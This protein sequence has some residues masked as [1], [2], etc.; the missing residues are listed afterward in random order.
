[1]LEYLQPLLL[2]KGVLLGADYVDV[3]GDIVGRVVPCLSL[4]LGE[5]PGRDLLGRGCITFNSKTQ[6]R[7]S[8][9]QVRSRASGGFKTGEKEDHIITKITGTSALDEGLRTDTTLHVSYGQSSVRS[10]CKDSITFHRMESLGDP[11]WSPDLTEQVAG[12]VLGSRVSVTHEMWPC[13]SGV[14][15]LNAE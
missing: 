2:S 10:C 4:P 3:M 12:H 6:H 5:K 1:M 9:R 8:Q 11:L 13:H 7:M 14:Y 15:I